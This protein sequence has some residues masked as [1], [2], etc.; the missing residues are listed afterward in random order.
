[1]SSKLPS[2]RL[3]WILIGLLVIISLF[4]F[5]QY[6]EAQSKLHSPQAAAANSK[7]VNDTLA[8]LAKLV[9]V[10]TDETPTVVTVAD[11]A[12]LKNQT[13]FAHAKA[14]DK[15]IVY[16]RAKQAILYRPSTNQIVTMAPVT[17][18]TN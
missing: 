16:A 17:G 6:R 8:K 10:P 15:V 1:M 2:R 4:L 14:G 3:P 13:F 12:K 18:S 5:V 11:P 9:I 7:Q